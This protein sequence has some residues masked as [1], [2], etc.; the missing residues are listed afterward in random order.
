MGLTSR[1]P[2][3]I[4]CLNGLYRLYAC[5]QPN[6]DIC[7]HCCTYVHNC[8]CVY[9]HLQ[10]KEFPI[11]NTIT[12]AIANCELTT[13]VHNPV[14][15]RS[16]YTY[17]EIDERLLQTQHPPSHLTLMSCTLHDPNTYTRTHTP[18]H[19]ILTH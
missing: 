1:I 4:L 3:N 10:H 9:V 12:P 5:T 18:S 16:L 6:V 7:T 13:Q 11:Y 19:M 2:N 17:T 15:T 14:S 8:T